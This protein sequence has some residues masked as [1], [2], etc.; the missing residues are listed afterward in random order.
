[1]TIEAEAARVAIAAFGEVVESKGHLDVT[2]ARQLIRLLADTFPVS[3]G[4]TRS[5]KLETLFPAVVRMRE[6]QG[7]YFVTRDR[8]SD[9]PAAKA[10]EREVDIIIAAILDKQGKLF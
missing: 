4:R 8:S 5:E 9:L 7:R 1:M 2:V 10:A 6:L 3:S